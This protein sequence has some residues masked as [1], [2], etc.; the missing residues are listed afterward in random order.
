MY[1]TDIYDTIA[2]SIIHYIDFDCVDIR[3]RDDD[4]TIHGHS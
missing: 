4:K 1:V 3:E 2:R